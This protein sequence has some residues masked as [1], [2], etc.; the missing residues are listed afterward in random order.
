MVSS[1]CRHTSSFASARR[2]SVTAAAEAVAA[3]SDAFADA[4]A[5][6]AAF[7]ASRTVS[8]PVFRCMRAV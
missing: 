1:R 8:L 2:A 5:A 3:L 7:L 6:P 4:R